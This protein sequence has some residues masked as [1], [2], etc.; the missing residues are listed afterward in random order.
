MDQSHKNMHALTGDRTRYLSLAQNSYP[1]AIY[2]TDNSIK[3]VKSSNII[4][5]HMNRYFHVSDDKIDSV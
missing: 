4:F 1:Y 2:T 5:C 3:I